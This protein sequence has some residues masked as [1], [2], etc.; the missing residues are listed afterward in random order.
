MNI[1]K[2]FGIIA[3]AL[4]LISSAQGQQTAAAGLTLMSAQATSSTQQ[5]WPGG[6]GVFAVSGTFAGATVTLQFV[7]P[8]GTLVTAGTS[9]TINAAGAG[10]FYLPRGLVQATITG[11]TGSTALSCWAKPIITFIG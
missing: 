10:V 9:T 2:R 8:D 6:G 3:M 1:L 7:G 11:A 5:I 4:C